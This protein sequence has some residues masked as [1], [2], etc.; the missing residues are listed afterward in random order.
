MKLSIQLDQMNLSFAQ[1]LWNQFLG[2]MPKLLLGIGLIILALIILKVVNFILKKLLKVSNIDSLTTKLN[3]AELF[4]KSDY[5]VVPSKIIL[6]FVKYFLILIFIVIASDMLGLKMVSEGIGSFIAYLP[7]L[8]SALLIFVV[9]VYM[10]SLIKNAIHDTFKSLELSGANLVG[11]I[12]FY[13]IV[14][15]VSITALNQAEIE[16]DIITNN[17]TLI[18]GS[19]LI[20]FTIAFGLGA[21]DIVT[22]LLFG[23]YSRKNFEVGQQ[24]KTENFEGVIQQIDNIC[25][26]IK[27]KEGTVVLPIKKF[28][29]QDIEIK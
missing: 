17:L 21:R 7:V 22:R 8:I 26:T 28:V 2:F 23:F 24:I 5:T 6:K 1:D 19:V 29:D 14:V 15:V 4:G 27:T 11:N 9:G 3:D 16:T 25:I 18:L 12:A 20:A 10:A 13:A